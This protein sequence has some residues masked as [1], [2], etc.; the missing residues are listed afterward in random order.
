MLAD[1]PQREYPPPEDLDP[2]NKKAKPPPKKK[3]KQPAFPTPEWAE[4]LSAV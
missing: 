2:K 4:E 3:K 1:Y